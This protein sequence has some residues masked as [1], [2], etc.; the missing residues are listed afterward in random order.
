[1]SRRL[2]SWLDASSAG[3][4]GIA[5]L[6][7]YTLLRPEATRGDVLRL[8]DEAVAADTW[9]VCVNGGWVSTCVARLRRTTIR[10]VGVVG[11]PLGAAAGAAKAAEAAGALADGATELD[12]VLAL[13]RAKAG[14]WEAVTEDVALV[15]S[16]ARRALVKVIVESAV[17]D[18]SELVRACKAAVAGG[19]GF[20]KTSTGFHPA[21]GA[22]PEVVRRMRAAVGTTIGVKASGGIR[23]AEQAVAMIAAGA[24][25]IG[26]SSLSGLRAI[27]GAHA[28]SLREILDAQPSVT[29]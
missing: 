2:P 20:V 11:F 26:L 27:I 5:H 8:C 6:L 22:T 19:A 29:G 4:P 13:G 3:R 14:D 25:R 7:D 12:V 1:M 17:L 23:T 10:V 15:V 9:A 21:G 28:P 16:A 18:S 24:N